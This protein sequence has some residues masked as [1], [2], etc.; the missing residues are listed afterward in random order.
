[1]QVAVGGAAITYFS[2]GELL[3]RLARREA[4]AIVDARSREAYVESGATLR[5]AVR[6]PAERLS[7]RST[8]IPRGRTLVLIADLAEAEALATALL[9]ED[10]FTDVCLVTGGFEALRAAGAPVVPVKVKP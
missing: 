5:G 2:P 10:G 4:L 7:A 6:V 1:M 9:L 3:T 8:E